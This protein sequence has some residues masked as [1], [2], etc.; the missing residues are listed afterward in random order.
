MEDFNI[1]S[2]KP[3][4]KKE[5]L[6]GLRTVNFKDSNFIEEKEKPDEFQKLLASL[7]EEIC[8]LKDDEARSKIDKYLEVELLQKVNDKELK[9]NLFITIEIIDRIKNLIEE[10][11]VQN[12]SDL[13]EEAK[14]A[15]LRIIKKIKD[16]CEKYTNKY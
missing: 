7:K 2:F 15:S 10:Y 13:D 3:A 12:D 8:K 4:E 16:H 1:V 14:E 11:E 5:K 6:G 9:N